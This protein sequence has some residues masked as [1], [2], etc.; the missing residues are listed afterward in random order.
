M[1]KVQAILQIAPPT[2]IKQVQS[3]VGILNHYKSMILHRSHLLTPIIELTKNNVKFHWTPTCQQSFEK[4]KQ[5][6][7]KCISLVY[8][9]FSL[10]IQANCFLFLKTHGR[11]TTLYSHQT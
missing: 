2:N 5:L 8:P 10:T 9:D 3:F 4:V 1:K 6:L 11:A 7:A